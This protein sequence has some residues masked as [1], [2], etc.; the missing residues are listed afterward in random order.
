MR[1]IEPYPLG[2]RLPPGFGALTKLQYLDLNGLGIEG[3]LPAGMAN[4]TGLTHLD[5]GYNHLEGAVPDGF[6]RLTNLQYLDMSLSPQLD[7]LLL[8]DVVKMTGLS[9]CDLGSG[10][11]TAGQAIPAAIGD[12]KQ[13]QLLDLDSSGISGAIPARLGELKALV[14]LDL[15]GNPLQGAIPAGTGRPFGAEN[16]VAAVDPPDRGAG[17]AGQPVEPGRPRPG[18]QRRH[19]H[20]GCR[21]VGPAGQAKDAEPG[22]KPPHRRRHRLA[23]QTGDI[24]RPPSWGSA[25]SAARCLRS[26]G[27]RSLKVA[28]SGR[29]Q[30]HGA[31]G[32]D[33]PRRPAN[34]GPER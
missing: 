31:A 1:E 12:L 22:R 16:P 19:D 24:W 2:G 11:V 10:P 8:A 14:T 28:G 4:M 17:S 20:P 18:A 15:G 23:G 32:E 5:L 7:G 13:L 34:A 29:E 30:A 26:M 9:Y 25:A 3:A 21:L 27:S 33:R 6:S